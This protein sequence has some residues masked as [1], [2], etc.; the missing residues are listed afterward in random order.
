MREQR[1]IQPDGTRNEGSPW[2]PVPESPSSLFRKALSTLDSL[3][4]VAP[5]R[6]TLRP[7]ASV[8]E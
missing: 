6:H 1:L 3:Q 5:P 2:L 7:T 4:A 8:D